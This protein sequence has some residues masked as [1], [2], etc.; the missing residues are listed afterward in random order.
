MAALINPWDVCKR[1]HIRPK[2]IIYDF[3]LAVKLNNGS[4]TRHPIKTDGK[5][6][7]WNIDSSR[8]H[9]IQQL[10]FCGFDTVW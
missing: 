2:R 9:G 6:N 10:H 7:K 4:S 5:N 1:I 3:T 8:L